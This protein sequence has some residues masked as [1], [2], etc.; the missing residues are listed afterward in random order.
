MFREQILPATPNWPKHVCGPFSIDDNLI[1]ECLIAKLF[2]CNQRVKT[3]LIPMHQ[4]YA[5]H[6]GQLVDFQLNDE[7]GRGR[8]DAPPSHRFEQRNFLVI[9]WT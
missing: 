2:F 8:K 5:G 1:I 4:S 6:L 9:I 3:L 7:K